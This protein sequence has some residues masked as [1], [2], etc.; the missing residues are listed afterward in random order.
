MAQMRARMEGGG[1]GLCGLAHMFYSS[2]EPWVKACKGTQL[3]VLAWDMTI[4]RGGGELPLDKY[5]AV[6]GQKTQGTCTS[7]LRY[8]VTNLSWQM[9]YCDSV[10]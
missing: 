5:G 9:I 3:K 1:G 2:K 10:Q 4:K 7:N 8:S 6:L